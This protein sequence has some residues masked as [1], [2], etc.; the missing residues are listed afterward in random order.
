MIMIRIFLFLLLPITAF[1]AGGINTTTELLAA[2]QPVNTEC[3]TAEF[4]NALIE[5]AYMVSEDDDRETVRDWI[6]DIL[7]SPEV[8]GAVLSCPEIADA[9]ETATLFMPIKYTFP[10][11]R[12]IT[13]NYETQPKVLE[14]RFLLA[15]KTELPT[16]DPNPEI[17]STDPHATW[18]N[19]DPAWYG[20]MVT[21]SGAL[22]DFVG[23]GKNNTISMKWIENNI[24]RLYPQNMDGWCSTKVGMGAKLHNTMVHDVIRNYTADMEDDDNNYYIAGDRNLKWISITEITIDVALTIATWGGWTFLTGAA[25]GARAAKIIPKLKSSLRTLLQYEKVQNYLRHSLQI[26]KYTKEIDNMSDMAKYIRNIDK[27]ERALAKTSQGSRKY[28]KIMKQL[29]AARKLKADNMWKLG[30]AGQ[31]IDKVEDIQKLDKLIV[32][33][34]TAIADIEKEMATLAKNDANVAE[35]AKQFNELENVIAYS[36][37]LKTFKNARTGNIITRTWQGIK[38]AR[39]SAK[40]AYG[41]TK[42]LDKASR[43]ART[44]SK[45]GRARDWLFHSSMR[46]AARVTRVA[47]NVTALSFVVGIIGGFYDWTTNVADEYTNGIEMKPL[48]L[49]SADSLD[50]YDNVVNYGMWLMWAGD[51]T[52]VADD[53]A[54]YLQA[55]D[56]AQ[57]F[58]QD[59]TQVQNETGRHA[60]DID[61]YVVR[62]VIRNPNTDN[63]E[64]YWLVMNDEPWSP[65]NA[66]R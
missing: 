2:A 22:R 51:T 54:A 53:D 48:L 32:Q 45:S 21:Q 49:L 60:C 44:A 23:P 20:I 9:D 14:Q 42:T 52:S 39:Q 4:N 13:I 10:G 6:Y 37:Q 63:Q 55:M 40:A 38:N 17:S 27:L 28:E 36:K 25:K 24:D 46:N 47:A 7:Q 12:E 50:E 1:A 26:A 31:G 5:N 30:Q 29:E 18:V 59:L 3:A 56:F 35:Y 8:L 43:V 11:G 58:Y 34:R 64:L 66:A 57:K 62:P 61:I 65:G 15:S 33:N 41:G 16:D 19:T